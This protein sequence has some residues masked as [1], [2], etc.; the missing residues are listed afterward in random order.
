MEATKERAGLHPF[1]TAKYLFWG[2]L[3]C[4]VVGV[5]GFLGGRYVAGSQSPPELSAVVL[6]GRLAEISELAAV[7]YSYTNMAQFENSNDFYG[8]TLPFTTKRFILTYDGTIKA[9]IDLNRV[10]IVVE[11]NRVQVRLPEARIL[12]HEIAEDSVEIFDEKTSIFNP[13]TV[14]DFT[15]FQAAQKQVMEEKALARGLLEQAGEKAEGS[16]RLLLEELLPEGAELTV[17]QA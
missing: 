8:M 4:A 13:F 17:S 7:T 6:E 14:E 15:S 10:E 3:L 16:V 2:I 11:G 1:K 12:S 9:G 5:G